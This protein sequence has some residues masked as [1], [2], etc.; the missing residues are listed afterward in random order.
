MMSGGHSLTLAA[1]ET[2]LL[3]ARQPAAY[4][5]P[6]IENRVPSEATS[7]IQKRKSDHGAAA[8]TSISIFQS[9]RGSECTAM[10]VRAGLCG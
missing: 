1:T 7:V 5:G 4:R 10:V 3:E 2:T 8:I 9:G 6:A